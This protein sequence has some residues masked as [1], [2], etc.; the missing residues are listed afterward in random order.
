MKLNFQN[1]ELNINLK[2][3]KCINSYRCKNKLYEE[4]S[5]PVISVI[6]PIYNG[7]QYMKKSIDIILKQTFKDFEL[8]L[9]ND[10]SNDNSKEI[11]SEYAEQDRRIR[12]I[13][14]E[15]GG[16][17]SARN[18]GIDVV[19]GKYIMFLDCDD[20]Y[21]DTLLEEM[22]KSIEDNKADLVICGQIDVIVNE[23]NDV[24]KYN[25]VLPEG[26]C[27]KSNDEILKNYIYLREKYIAD[28]L[29]NKIYKA[30]IIK[31][32]NLRFQN[33]KRG[34]DAIFNANY[35]EKINKCITLNKALYYYRIEISNPIWL[36]YSKD[37]YNVLSDENEAISNKLKQ[38]GRYDENAISYQSLHFIE[39]IMGYFEWINYSQNSF[40]FK[41]KYLKIKQ[42]LNK[43]KVKECL[44]NSRVDKKGVFRKV[45]IKSMR[46]KNTLGI[47]FL[48]KVRD[49]IKVSLRYIKLLEFKNKLLKGEDV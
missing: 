20:W 13:N 3:L 7:A 26:Q 25:K 42:L 4:I 2:I 6:M 12:V 11:C 10:G 21:E 41:E 29:W 1:G 22:Y 8:I 36:K 33:F 32:F 39:E 48:F 34:E 27:Y 24:I 43:D 45:V 23:K 47:L 19:E 46:S 35:Y 30:H 14:K 38:W 18:K 17:W 49:M 9:V 28:V 5:M 16:A 37:Y 31:E 40:E 15:N 44:I